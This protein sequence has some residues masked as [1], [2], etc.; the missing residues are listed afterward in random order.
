MS[1]KKLV[2]ITHAELK[3]EKGMKTRIPLESRWITSS[4]L[5][6]T[7]QRVSEETERE[8]RTYVKS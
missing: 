1:W 5:I 6:L 7:L 3:K 2:Q 4:V 8:Q